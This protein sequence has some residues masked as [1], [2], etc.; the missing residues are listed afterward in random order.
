MVETENHIESVC[1]ECGGTLEGTKIYLTRGAGGNYS[2]S[3]KMFYSKPV[4]YG[5][6]HGWILP[7]TGANYTGSFEMWLPAG[8]PLGKGLSDK[9]PPREFILIPTH[10]TFIC[11][12]CGKE[13][14]VDC[15]QTEE[16]F[17]HHGWKTFDNNELCFCSTCKWPK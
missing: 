10:K 12:G 3:L 4:N 6:G 2:G 13:L 16:D 17:E 14:I 8:H 15:N 5:T 7:E 1:P 9:D 11:E